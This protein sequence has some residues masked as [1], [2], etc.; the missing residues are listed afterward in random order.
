MA[1]NIYTRRGDHGTTDLANG[2]SVT[3][4]HLCVE[5]YGT[6]DE[7]NAHL[8][9]LLTMMT[10]AD[11]D[12][13]LQIQRDLFHLGGWVA[14]VP[15]DSLLPLARAVEA[16]EEWI[17]EAALMVGQLFTG[18]VLPGGTPLAAQAHVSRTV[19][20]RAERR[21]L[22]FLRQA[23][24]SL[25][26]SACSSVAPC[27]SQSSC[28]ENSDE[29]HEQTPPLSMGSVALTYLNRLSDVLY[30]LA[31]KSHFLSGEKENYL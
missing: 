5:T 12:F 28:S 29:Q 10:G 31:K 24:P 26:S 15:C 27:R 14:G 23:D 3:K 13:L 8:G 18:F 19:C 20:R 6:L 11:R 9:V 1:R 30:V 17:D 16:L 2:E 21:L 7:L 4:D 25:L 22:T